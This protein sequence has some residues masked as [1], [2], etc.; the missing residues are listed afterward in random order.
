[1]T[2][3]R[4]SVLVALLVAWLGSA[5]AFAAD[6][7]L[8]I[9]DVGQGDGMLIL[10]PT[11]KTVLVDGGPPE[12]RAKLAARIKELV[13]GPIDLMIMT[14]PHA[15][16]LGGL[17]AVLDAV[18][19]RIFMEPGFDHPSPLYNHLLEALEKKKVPL[20]IG[21]AGRNI[22]LGG[23]AS[24]HLLAPSKPFL[25]NTRSD[26][27]ACSI[28]FRMTYGS[29]SFFLA[30]D[31][32]DETEQRILATGETLA[33][34]VYKVAHHG[35]RHSSS[36]ALLERIHP[37][38]AVVSVGA[39]NDYG[40][41]TRAALERLEAVN[42]QVLRTD[43]E[44]EIVLKS[45]GAKVTYVTEKGSGIAPSTAT[46]PE[47]FA[48]AAEPERH[49][50]PK[51]GVHIEH[52]RPA[53]GNAAHGFAAS[54]SSR[55]FHRDDCANVSHIKAAKVVRFASR[56]EATASGRRPAKDCNP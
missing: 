32:E 53:T 46:S 14:H 6:L 49:S 12:A 30:A 19:A 43:L 23:G 44:G 41:P 50:A 38:I 20:K 4:L 24:M 40:H 9:F 10:S 33:S 2:A 45:D 37:K 13:H 25:R 31:S 7:T 21:E 1:M 56:D 34:D 54:R 29:T 27:N 3:P 16:H 39:R 55:V 28:V 26:V 11:G 51:K 47:V 15:D 35:S 48:S 18:G 8:H 36:G 5:A 52:E 17:E 22:D 42:A